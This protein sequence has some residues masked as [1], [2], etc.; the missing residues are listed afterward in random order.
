MSLTRLR[1]S[2]KASGGRGGDEVG[3]PGR[4]SATLTVR[5]PVGCWL[6]RA[7]PQEAAMQYGG[8]DAGS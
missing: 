2:M 4:V 8:I 6:A 3:L 1:D 5:T 7:R